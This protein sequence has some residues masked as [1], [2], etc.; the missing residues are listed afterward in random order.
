MVTLQQD[1]TKFYIYNNKCIYKYPQ[2]QLTHLKYLGFIFDVTNIKI[3]PKAITKYYYRM[4]RKARNIV[5][6]N[7][8][9]SKGHHIS[10]LNLYRVYA[11]NNNKSNSK[12]TQTFID[13]AKKAK[14]Y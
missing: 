12:H 14:K 2:N 5:R 10:A 11:S 6:C 3:N 7:W 8:T 13:Y 4:Q 1:K 9:S